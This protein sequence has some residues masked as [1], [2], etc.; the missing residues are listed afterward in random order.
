MSDLLRLRRLNGIDRIY[1]R[2][3]NQCFR[4]SQQFRLSLGAFANITLGGAELI[5]LVELEYIRI[6]NR[7]NRLLRYAFGQE[8]HRMLVLYPIDNMSIGYNT[9]KQTTTNTNDDNNTAANLES[10][11]IDMSNSIQLF[12][13]EISSAQ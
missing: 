11:I 9:S 10:N 5:A 2:I 12:C 1:A 8:F 7:Y 13:H 6:P 4:R 3:Q